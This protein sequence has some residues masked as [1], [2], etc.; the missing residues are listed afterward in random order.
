MAKIKTIRFRENGTI[1]D[2]HVPQNTED[3]TETTNKVFVT[4]SQRTKLNNIPSITS[5]DVTKWNAK[6]SGTNITGIEVYSSSDV[7]ESVTKSPNVLYIL[8]E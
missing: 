4:S 5:S 8:T 1:I 3:L 7:F 2:L 6:V